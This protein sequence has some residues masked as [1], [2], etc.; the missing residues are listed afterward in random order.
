MEQTIEQQSLS[1][2][3]MTVLSHEE[4]KDHLG[5]SDQLS[6]TT[7]K[8][9]DSGFENIQSDLHNIVTQ[10]SINISSGKFNLDDVEMNK[11]T[12]NQSNQTESIDII[13][14]GSQKYV[15]LV[16]LTLPQNDIDIHSEV[17]IEHPTLDTSDIIGDVPDSIETNYHVN[18]VDPINITDPSQIYDSSMDPN[19]IQDPVVIQ[20]LIVMDPII[21]PNPIVVDPI[22]IPVVAPDPIIDPVVIPGV[23]PVVIPDP[24]IVIDPVVIPVVDPVVIPDPIIVPDPI[25]I[26]VV[27]P[28][29]VP[30][31]VVIPDPIVVIDPVVVIVDPVVIPVVPVIVVPVVVPTKSSH[32]NEIENSKN[33]EEHKDKSFDGHGNNEHLQGGAENDTF[34]FGDIHGHSSVDGGSGN[35]IDTIEMSGRPGEHGSW[36]VEINNHEVSNN[37]EH[38]SMDVHGET[39]TVHTEHGS[40]DFSNIDKIDW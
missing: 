23:D 12:N 24:I 17:Q 6:N 21:A 31:P 26:P 22:L 40:I 3:E 35:W 20:D 19:I 7:L 27:D 38:G 34:H 36:T 13:S 28:I 1:F 16:D 4:L 30:D 14:D 10:N 9:E 8:V 33:K 32:D 11:S 39:G 5:Q 15:P 37:H 25:V 18:I 29:I 2:D